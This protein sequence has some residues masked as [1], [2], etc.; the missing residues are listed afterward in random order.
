M[1][2]IN[3]KNEAV[4]AADIFKELTKGT[5]EVSD[6]PFF[7][8]KNEDGSFTVGE[9]N[10]PFEYEEFDAADLHKAIDKFNTERSK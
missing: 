10:H 5:G 9:L 6:M 4:K 2:L 3:G 7:I 8:T 1:S